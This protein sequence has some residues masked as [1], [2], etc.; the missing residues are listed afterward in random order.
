MK[1]LASAKSMFA[2]FEEDELVRR[3]TSIMSYGREGWSSDQNYVGPDG[4]VV[5][6][7]GRRTTQTPQHI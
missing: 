1:K 3:P 6:C 4:A 5:Y 7:R 2:H